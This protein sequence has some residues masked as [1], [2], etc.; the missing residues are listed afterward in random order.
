M[1]WRAGS[2]AGTPDR[3]GHLQI[4]IEGQIYR[5]HRLAWLWMTGEWPNGVIDHIDGVR[6]N[7]AWANLR[8]A[9]VSV[10][11][12][13]MRNPMRHG[14]SGYLGVTFVKRR[15]K[16]QAQIGTKQARMFLGYYETAE[17]AHAAYLAAKRQLHEGN[18]L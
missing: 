9:T 8:D 12:Q 15:N 16:F 5:S 2:V 18:M 17:A 13:N 1:R 4:Q 6:H 11:T 7:N 3:K 10:N 14:T